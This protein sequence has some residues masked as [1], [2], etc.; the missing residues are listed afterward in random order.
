VTLIPAAVVA[1]RLL[2]SRNVDLVL[3]ISIRQ[4]I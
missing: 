1:V 3:M 4:G 2:V